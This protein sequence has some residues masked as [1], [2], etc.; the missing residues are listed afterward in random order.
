MA[1]R[2]AVFIIT[3]KTG[4]GK[5]TFLENLIPGL[6]KQKLSVTG[7]LALRNSNKEEVQDYDLKLIDTNVSPPLA[8]RGYV[9]GWTKVSN[10]YF[11]P[12]ALQRGNKILSD[13][14][15]QKRDIVV[16]DEIGIFELDG[17]IWA[18]AV[19][20]LINNGSISMIWVVRNALV[21]KVITKWALKDP[22]IIDIEKVSIKDAE[23]MILAIF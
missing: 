23:K 1:I 18:N 14:Q 22:V 11:N 17:K 13:P 5:T 19:S 2:Q 4:S 9:K 12:E 20:R 6:R 16:I 7:F 3:G 10:F 8:S 15:I 21:E